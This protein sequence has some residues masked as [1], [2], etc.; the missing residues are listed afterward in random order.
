MYEAYRALGWLPAPWGTGG[1]RGTHLPGR[2]TGT[3][4]SDA[5][6]SGPVTVK[7]EPPQLSAGCGQPGREEL[8]DITERTELERQVRRCRAEADAAS[9][10]RSDLL[11][12]MGCE[13]GTPLHAVLGFAQLLELDG[14]SDEQRQ[15]VVRI[16]GAARHLLSLVNDVRDLGRIQA[17]QLTL[18][19]HPV[20][21]SQ[22]IQQAIAQIRPA[23]ER[24]RITLAHPGLASCA[25]SVLADQ[26]RL[27]QV[28]VHVLSNAVTYNREGGRIELD[29]DHGDR[30]AGGAHDGGAGVPDGAGVHRSDAGPGVVRLRVRDTGPG[31]PAADLE[32]LFAPFDRLGAE[33]VGIDGSG[34]GLALSRTLVEALGGRIEVASEVGVGSTFTV[35]LDAAGSPARAGAAEAGVTAQLPWAAAAAPLPAA[36]LPAATAPLPCVATPRADVPAVARDRGRPA[37]VVLYVED[38]LSSLRLL[39][40]IVALRPSWRLVHARHGRLAVELARSQEVDVVLLDLHLRDLPGWQV[41]DQLRGHPS[42]A[43]IPVHVLGTRPALGRWRRLRVPGAAGYLSKP[44]DVAEVGGLLDALQADQPPGAPTGSGSA[45]WTTLP[46]ACSR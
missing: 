8:R 35:V 37:H 16:S 11:A 24:R 23:A 44:L 25:E 43:R 31:V 18:S 33:Q 5:V 36:P 46:P 17:G 29:W 34:V 30:V 20:S 21:L 41:L 39:E 13:L 19:R 27:T 14:L 6:L 45:W 2:G 3:A 32:R 7:A 28:L 42:T 15:A 26:E 38:G 22:V 9:A 12:R 40:R 1:V 10:A 4:V